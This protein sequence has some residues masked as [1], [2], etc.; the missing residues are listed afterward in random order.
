M[1]SCDNMVLATFGVSVL[2]PFTTR[3]AEEVVSCR[4][5][6]KE[7][8]NE[9]QAQFGSIKGWR[10]EYSKIML[11]SLLEGGVSSMII[12]LVARM[13]VRIYLVQGIPHY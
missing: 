8:Q 5:L 6:I 11:I 10:L 12:A 7:V 4:F 3:F 2:M 1:Q 13:T 9:F